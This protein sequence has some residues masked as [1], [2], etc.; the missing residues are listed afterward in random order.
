MDPFP[1]VKKRSCVCASLVAKAAPAYFQQASERLIEPLTKGLSH[2]HSRVR[3]A[4]AKAIG[5]KFLLLLLLLLVAVV[6]AG[7]CCL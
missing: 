6:V 7:Y 4:F 2:Q 5:K 3:V 1:D